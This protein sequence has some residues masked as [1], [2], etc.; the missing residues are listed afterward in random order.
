MNFRHRFSPFFFFIYT[1]IPK[2]QVFRT[3]SANFTFFE[4]QDPFYTI[5]SIAYID[6]HYFF[7]PKKLKFVI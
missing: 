1:R 2:G 3:P 5:M 7:I 6:K 4:K